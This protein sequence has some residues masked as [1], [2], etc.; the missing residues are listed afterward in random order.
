M[1]GNDATDRMWRPFTVRY[2][3][4]IKAPYSSSVLSQSEYKLPTKVMETTLK[5]VNATSL[6]FYLVGIDYS[7]EFYMYFHFA[8]VE[9]VQDKLRKLT[10]ILNDKTIV[11]PIEP[12]YMVSHTCP[13]QSLSGNW[14]KISIAQTNQSALPPII[15][16]MEIYMVQKLL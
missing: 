2:G 7:Q 14:L 9:E 6:D 3:K 1:F 12:K 4:F 15:N 10:I 16:A 11:G 5:V 13:T 8:A